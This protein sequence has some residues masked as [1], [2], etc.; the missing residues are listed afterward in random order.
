MH[1]QL[2][3][4]FRYVKWLDWVIPGSVSVQIYYIILPL[5][6]VNAPSLPGNYS[7]FCSDKAQRAWAINGSLKS[8][9]TSSK[10]RERLE[11][12]LI[13]TFS[14]KQN[15]F[16][17]EHIKHGKFDILIF[18][19]WASTELWAEPT[20]FKSFD[21][22]LNSHAR[23]ASS[24]T[25]V[26]HMSAWLVNTLRLSLKDCPTENFQFMKGKTKLG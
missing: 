4:P 12:S 19:D 21:L 2:A 20:Q 8:L 17:I 7:I 11:F 3:I 16:L 25:R 26:S 10:A 15:S 23:Q 13:L 5:R 14:I 9:W 24:L 1:S 22:E 6:G 18:D